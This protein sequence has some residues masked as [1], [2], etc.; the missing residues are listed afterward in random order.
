MYVLTCLQMY[1]I[2]TL[3][4]PVFIHSSCGQCGLV[5]AYS[6]DSDP[7]EG[8]AEADGGDGGQDKLTDWKKLACL[9]CRRQFP[10]K[11][12][13]IRHQQLSDL[14]KVMHV[15]RLRC[16]SRMS[17]WKTFNSLRCSSFLWFLFPEKPG[18]SPQIPD[19]WSGAG[20]A[21]EEGD[22]GLIHSMLNY[23]A[24]V[25]GCFSC[26]EIDFK[27]FNCFC[28]S[29]EQM[30]YRDRAAERREKYG[31]PEPPAPKKKKFNQPAP[32]V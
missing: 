3:C 26:K 16:R 25:S 13:L 1:F 30:K 8:G 7:E 15:V 12:G 29:G 6:G 23:R 19:E 2:W 4:K 17:A 32:V 11:E 20:R 9:L 24:A 27:N 22:W 31:I 10:N 28:P 18:G 21:G 5:A 14:H